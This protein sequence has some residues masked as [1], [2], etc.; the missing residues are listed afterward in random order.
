MIVPEL[1]GSSSSSAVM[2]ELLRLNLAP[3]GIVLRKPDAIL[4]LGIIVAQEMGWPTVPV[5][6]ADPDHFV[7]GQR[8]R[9][10]VDGQIDA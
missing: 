2:L 8:L 10:R 1:V 4:C 9:M 6:Q 5:V 3:A 7:S